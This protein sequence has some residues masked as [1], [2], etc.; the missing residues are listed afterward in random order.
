MENERIYKGFWWLPSS[1]DKQVAGTLTVD[2]DG[3]VKLELLG[4]FLHDNELFDFEV[5]DEAVILGRCYD[6]KSNMKDISL[7]RCRSSYTMN[8]GSTFP[9]TRYTCRYALIG[10]HIESMDDMSFFKAHVGFKEMFYWCPPTNIQTCFNH[11]TISVIIDIEENENKIKASLALEDETK[12]LIKEA[13]SYKPDYPDVNI[14]QSTFWEIQKEDI[15]AN[16]VL[17]ITNGFERFLSLATLMPVEHGE[18][19]LFSKHIYQELRDGV[20]FYHPIELITPLYKSDK[21][22]KIEPYDF[23]FEYED[24]ADDFGSLFKKL[25]SDKSIAQILSNLID[26]FEKKRT[27][28]SNDFLV[29]AQALDGFAM[30]FRQENSLFEEYKSLR[31][32]FDGIKKLKL[33][34]EDLKSAVGSR[35]YYSHILKIEKKAHKHALDGVDLYH[36]TKKLQILLICCVLNFMGVSNDRINKLLNKSNNTLFL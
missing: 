26:S 8:I 34:D 21:I 35:D 14:S 36:L 11:K 2:S 28:T 12:L 23:L 20:N 29:V 16:Q 9:I 18:I 10:I 4:S 17:D 19:T 15:S 3:N 33:T 31:N 22:Y 1:S 13:A 25:Y 27:Y 30:R 7:I 6:H 24:I 5:D 32:E